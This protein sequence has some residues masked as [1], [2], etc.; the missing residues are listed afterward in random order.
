MSDELKRKLSQ[1]EDDLKQLRDDRA[2]KV[3]ARDTAKAAFAATDGY[4][5]DSDEF[6]A[7]EA[8]IK[9]VGELDDRIASTQAAQVGILKMLGQTDPDFGGSDPL[10]GGGRDTGKAGRWDSG[11]LLT[12]EVL[13]TLEKASSSTGRFGQIELGKIADRDALKAELGSSNV[14]GLIQPDQRGLLPYLYRPLRLLDLIPSGATDSSSVEYVQVTGM[15]TAAAETA[16]GAVKP[17]ETYGFTDATALIRTIAAWVKIRKQTLADAAGLQTFLDTALRYDVRRRLEAQVA[18]GDGAGQNIRGILNTTGVQT[19]TVGTAESGA[20]RIHH[21]V[22]AVQ[23]ADQ[24]PSFVGLHPLDWEDIRLSRD[25]SGAGAGTGGYLFGPPSQVG[26]PTIWGL[27]PVV[28][29]SFPQG[30]ALVGDANA[31]TV[32]IREGLNVLISDSDQDDF[33]R[34]RVTLLGEMRAGL[35]VWRPNGFAEVNLGVVA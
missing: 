19:P 6:K 20:D 13:E 8:A 24:E 11:K 33:I 28:S 12:P 15:G 32:L 16:E 26:A 35:V 34:N 31:A 30:T 2:E 21:G 9:D 5:T 4:D 14:A 1:V 25:D 10:P 17:E 27:P 22:V 3:R 7:A 23:L 29:T 18:N